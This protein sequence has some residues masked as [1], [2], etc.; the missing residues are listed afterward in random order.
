MLEKFS[1]AF[2]CF[3]NCMEKCP[4]SGDDSRLDDAKQSYL[5][6]LYFSGDYDNPAYQDKIKNYTHELEKKI[7]ERNYPYP[8]VATRFRIT[9]GDILFSRYYCI[10]ERLGNEDG[11]SSYK[12]KKKNEKE[13][14]ERKDLVQMYRK[15]IEACNYKAC[16][17]E[18]SFEAGLRVL[19]RRI[20]MLPDRGSLDI[21]RDVFENIW[22]EG[23][24]LQ[25]KK[26]E[27]KGILEIIRMR[28]LVLQYEEE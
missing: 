20:E 28:S 1:D 7:G 24:Q 8:W 27:R 21:L 23:E 6:A 17:N 19:R 14:V 10:E 16:Y 4:E 13:K 5:T 3:E 9:Q 22:K 26:E 25:K 11:Y 2:D 12:F 18:L 15:Y